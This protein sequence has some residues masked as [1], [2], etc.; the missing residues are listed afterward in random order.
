MKASLSETINEP[1]DESLQAEIMKFYYS[2]TNEQDFFTLSL[3]EILA[4]TKV[5]LL[6][7]EDSNIVGLAGT[8]K[9]TF[10]SLYFMVVRHDFQG[11]GFGKKLISKVLVDI[12]KYTLLM[13]TVGRSNLNARRLY[14]TVDFKTIFRH[15]SNAFMIYNNK[16]GQWLR[17]PMIIMLFLKT[18][19][20]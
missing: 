8:R 19:I 3:E 7:D 13:L 14:H 12:P 17:W 18:R 6:Y 11:Q 9:K 10:M 2:L 1:F 4:A 20:S 5:V 16:I 15:K